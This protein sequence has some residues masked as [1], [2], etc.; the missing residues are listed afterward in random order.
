[1]NNM[2]KHTF[3]PVLLGILAVIAGPVLLQGCGSKPEA[4]ATEKAEGAKRIT[5]TSEYNAAT[6]RPVNGGAG[7]PNSSGR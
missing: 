1:M 7:A 6:G 5:P 3:V 4:T 2:K